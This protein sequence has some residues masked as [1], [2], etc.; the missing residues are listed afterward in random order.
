MDTRWNTA[1][2]DRLATETHSHPSSALPGLFHGA[3]TIMQLESIHDTAQN[4]LKKRG[5]KLGDYGTTLLSIDELKDMG[6]SSALLLGASCGIGIPYYT[7]DHSGLLPPGGSEGELGNI[8]LLGNPIA[9]YVAAP[10]S[11]EKVYALG[12]LSSRT[13]IITEGEFKAICVE[14][15]IKNE[16]LSAK[17]I[18]LRGVD[19]WSG[20]SQGRLFLE[21]LMDELDGVEKVYII[22]D[23]DGTDTGEKFTAQPKPPVLM[24]ERKLA[25]GVMAL[26]IEVHIC[27]I[28]MFNRQERN[29]KFAIDDH[30]L[31][32]GTLTDVLKYAKRHKHMETW[33]ETLCY[34]LNAYGFYS[35]EV[36][37]L[38]TGLSLA[39]PKAE[40]QWTGVLTRRNDDDRDVKVVSL[41]EK[42]PRTVKIND[43]VYDPCSK[44]GFIG[45]G[46]F[47]MFKAW[48]P[49]IDGDVT[50]WTSLVDMILRDRPDEI[51]FLHNW[52]GHIMQN[53]GQKNATFITLAGEENGSGKST[54]ARS[55][56]RM[57]EH[58]GLVTTGARLF[59]NYNKMLEG[60]VFVTADEVSSNKASHVNQL[61][62][63]VTSESM[64]IEEK[65]QATRVVPNI[66]NF[67]FTTNE[68]TSVLVSKHNRRDVIMSIP[69]HGEAGLV[70]IMHA[71]SDFVHWRDAQDGLAIMRRWYEQRDLSKYNPY[72]QAPRFEG[73]EGAVEVSKSNSR[74][75]TD[76]VEDIITQLVEDHGMI[77]LDMRTFSCLVDHVMPHS[78]Y[79]QVRRNMVRFALRRQN[80][81]IKINGI[82]T[83]CNIFGDDTRGR[84]WVDVYKESCSAIAK[85]IGA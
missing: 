5:L 6:L 1:S 23:Y 10:G 70:K 57:V 72:A 80:R 48:S 41:M 22:Y 62:D 16:K 67:I 44:Y 31:R 73:F 54:I 13:L 63:L 59:G 18:G 49:G 64:Q 61:K 32:G 78:D 2:W 68:V 60:K 58:A 14:K 85:Y 4:D 34:A 66:A 24:A 75:L 30:L 28:G 37:E 43:W 7:R 81:K 33:H 26:G 3:G 20:R 79:F 45:H 82:P 19:N 47:N 15:A 39:R 83:E 27:R 38:S 71:V 53:P 51:G 42:D 40:M 77:A 65:F 69:R 8:K 36:V 84:S 25:A 21:A 76:D 11:Y 52:V 46:R 35:G 55:I 9:K 29:A 56:V 17:V 74:M 50:P 12:P